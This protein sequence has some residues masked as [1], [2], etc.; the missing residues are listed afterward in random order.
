MVICQYNGLKILS[1]NEELV[2]LTIQEVHT[3]DLS[4]E[5]D[6]PTFLTG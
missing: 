5:V 1:H 3:L 6:L 2:T 4:Y